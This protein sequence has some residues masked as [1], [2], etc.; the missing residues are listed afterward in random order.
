[1]HRNNSA[2]VPTQDHA[3][4]RSRERGARSLAE[5]GRSGEGDRHPER[6]AVRI[7]YNLRRFIGA[8]KY[9]STT[10]NDPRGLGLE[11]GQY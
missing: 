4:Q 1:M 7:R 11:E 6:A 9:P 5:R 3:R 2:Y 10:S 8:G